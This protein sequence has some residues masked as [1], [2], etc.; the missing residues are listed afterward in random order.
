MSKIM[1]ISRRTLLS[2]AAGAATLAVSPRLFSPAIAQNTPLKVGLMLPYTG[3]FAK[4]GQFIDNGFEL[5]YQ[6]KGLKLGGREVQFIKVDDESKAGS[7]DRQHEPPGRARESRC[8]GRHRA[9]RC[10]HGDGEGGAGHQDH[11]HHSERGCQRRDRPDVRAEY[12]PHSFSNWQ[13]TYP[14]GKVLV[15]AGIKNVVT[16]TWRYTAGA[17][18][19][20]AFS[21]NFTKSGGKIVEDL[22]LPFPR[23]NSSALITRIATLKPMRCSSPVAAP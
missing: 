3:T 6:Q 1:K 5:Y 14:A 10:R 7:R 11:A 13:T 17:E 12:L 19:I 20:S 21:E 22:T 23:S 18:M 8:R 9:F 2:G 15:D 16:I 4:L